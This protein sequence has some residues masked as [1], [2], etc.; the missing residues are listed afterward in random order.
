MHGNMLREEPAAIRTTCETPTRIAL[1]G[2][3]GGWVLHT[4]RRGVRQGV[5]IIQ[6]DC[7][8]E[9]FVGAAL[10]TPGAPRLM[11]FQVCGSRGAEGSGGKGVQGG[12]QLSKAA[13]QVGGGRGTERLPRLRHS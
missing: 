2:I 4:G 9:T 1:A 10:D 6:G 5:G 13:L 11:H 3:V 12:S 7:D 8:V